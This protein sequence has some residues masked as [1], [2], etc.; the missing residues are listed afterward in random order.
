MQSRLEKAEMK[1]HNIADRLFDCTKAPAAP[2]IFVPCTLSKCA[3]A[4]EFARS[5]ARGGA[6]HNNVAMEA[7]ALVARL[8]IG[9]LR[10]SARREDL[11]FPLFC[12]ARLH[13]KHAG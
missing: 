4:P 6:V 3:D 5:K 13:L 1:A 11:L 2:E 7:V 9:H 10:R 12:S 8:H